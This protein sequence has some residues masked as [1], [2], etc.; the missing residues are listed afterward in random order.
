MSAESAADF[1]ANLGSKPEVQAP[2][3]E[4]QVKPTTQVV[5][6]VSN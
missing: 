5:E 1:F 2:A 6:E 4:K 3:P